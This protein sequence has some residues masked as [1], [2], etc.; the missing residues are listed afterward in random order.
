MKIFCVPVLVFAACAA[1]AFAAEIP[2]R[3]QK[4]SAEKNIAVGSFVMAKEI[5]DLEI[6][7]KSAGT[8][9]FEKGAGLTWKNIAPNKFTFFAN[10][11]YYEISAP[12]GSK[13]S[14]LGGFDIK[15]AAELLFKGDF[16]DLR[17]KFEIEVLDDSPEKIRLR[18]TPKISKIKNAMESATIV[19]G[20]KTLEKCAIVLAN[21]TIL[22]IEFKE[23]L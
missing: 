7:V 14:E 1:Q 9:R 21:G 17:E 11:L 3:L 15:A 20:A 22:N 5:P 10:S 2:A 18:L 4:W 16:S 8:F 13:K 12:D 19:F 23:T 6:S